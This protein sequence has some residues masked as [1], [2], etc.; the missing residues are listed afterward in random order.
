MAV[1]LNP[2]LL[3]QVEVA[4]ALSRLTMDKLLNV[5]RQVWGLAKS[6]LI[7]SETITRLAVISDL[8]AR[9]GYNGPYSGQNATIAYEVVSIFADPLSDK[10]ARDLWRCAY[11]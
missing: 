9:P 3:R 5:V 4:C 11:T 7:L 1:D 8:M 6:E 10:R 2:T